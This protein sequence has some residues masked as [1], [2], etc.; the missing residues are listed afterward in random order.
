MSKEEQHNNCRYCGSE[1]APSVRKCRHCGEWLRW[2][3]KNSFKMT[4]EQAGRIGVVVSL[5]LVVIQMNKSR[6]LEEVN[7]VSTV[8]SRYM[9][10]DRLL[11]EKPEYST[12]VVPVEDY[13]STVKL[14][15]S[16]EGLRR[17]Q[18]GQF[19]AYL[20]DAYEME[21]YLRD[22]YGLYPRGTEFVLEKFVTNPKVIE[23]WYAEGLRQWYSD[24]FRTYVEGKMPKAPAK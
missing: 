21:F 20:L 4:L 14:A 9:E 10:I 23:W 1:V 24:N 18:E 12:L 22:T 8:Q 17:L 15:S 6:L 7:A 2:T 5:I 3:W 11:L 19:I 16:R 13:E